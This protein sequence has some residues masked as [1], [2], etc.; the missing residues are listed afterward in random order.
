MSLGRRILF[1]LITLSLWIIIFIKWPGSALSSPW[2]LIP[3]F[4]YFFWRE[5]QFASLLI[6]S[7]G[8]SCFY[9]AAPAALMQTPGQFEMAF[10]IAYYVIALVIA[11][12]ILWVARKLVRQPLW[13]VLF[14]FALFETVIYLI[15]GDVAPMAMNLQWLLWP[16]LWIS[17]FPA[18]GNIIT[19]SVLSSPSWNV[20][21]FG[22]IPIGAG[23]Q[24]LHSVYS[25]LVENDST[26]RRSLLILASGILCLWIADMTEHLPIMKFPIKMT[27]FI[28][29]EMSVPMR[30]ASLI[31]KLYWMFIKTAGLANTAVGFA[32][33][34]GYH[35]PLGAM[36]FTDAKLAESWSKIMH[37]LNRLILILLYRPL[38][39]S[40]SFIKHRKL[41]TACAISFSVPIFGLMYIINRDV[42]IPGTSLYH[43][44][45]NRSVYLCLVVFFSLTMLYL[46]PSKKNS[47]PRVLGILRI[48]VASLF[49]TPVLMYGFLTLHNT[50]ATASPLEYFAYLFGF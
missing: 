29:A 20:N 50:G 17:I 7:F 14:I 34:S 8:H 38:I 5:K 30:W 2:I 13:R 42:T 46:R 6:A 49:L 19:E 15:R 32:R 11:T 47:V 45:V 16:F 28:H 44:V 39:K 18:T 21:L 40:F 4:S 22:G 26:T 37:Y 23:S 48:F 33:L 1:F 31:A 41:R 25:D 9:L 35:L 24:E 27:E 36:V 3:I 12:T 43:V 10:T